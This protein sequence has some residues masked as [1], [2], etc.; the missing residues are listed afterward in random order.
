MYSTQVINS[1][2]GANAILNQPFLVRMY[3]IRKD[4]DTSS[5]GDKG[6]RGRVR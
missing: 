5:S 2:A 3:F 6:Y 4:T 1:W